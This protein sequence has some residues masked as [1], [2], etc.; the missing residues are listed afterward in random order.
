MI[1]FIRAFVIILTLLLVLDSL[2]IGSMYKVFYS[3][4]IGNLLA[5]EINLLPA[6]L[7]YMIYAF[8]LAWLV[9]LPSLKHQ[10]SDRETTLKGFLFGLVAYSTY[11]LTNH[12]TLKGWTTAMTVV[13]IF[14][15]TLMTGV[16]TGITLWILK[17]IQRSA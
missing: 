4:N 8:G 12:A 17:K 2:W 3:P 7:F 16:V 1:T 13:D 6:L 15:G 11:N 14:W 9:V 10:W 5:E